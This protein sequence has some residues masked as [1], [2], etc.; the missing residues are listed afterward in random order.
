MPVRVLPKGLRSFDAQDAYFFLLL[1]PGPRDR[2]GLPQNIAFW[3]TRIEDTDAD[4]TFSVGLI[5]GPSGCGKSSLVKAGLLPRLSV[6]VI[7]VYLEAQPGETEARILR[8]LRKKCPALPEGLDLPQT[9]AAVRKGIGVPAGKKVLLVLDQFEQ[10]LHAHGDNPDAEL[11]RALRHCDGTHLQCVV[12]VRD[13]FWMA[14][15]RFMR[16]LEVRLRE[17]ENSTA[18]DLFNPR[19]ARKVLAEFGRAFGCLPDKADELSPEQEQFLDLAVA[20]LA[21]DGKIIP[22]R[23][24]L[25]TEML[26]NRAWTLETLRAVGGAHGSGVTFLEET[27]SAAT[28]PPEHRRHQRAAREVLR[29]LLPGHG[30]DI[31]GTMRSRTELSAASGCLR[32]GDFDELLHLLDNEL[33]LVT[34]ADPEDSPPDPARHKDRPSEPSPHGQFYQLTHDYLIPPLREWLTRKQRERWRGRAELTLAERTAQWSPAHDRRFLP[35]LL[36]FLMIR[37]GVPR[38]RRTRQQQALLMAAARHHTTLWGGLTLVVLALVIALQQYIAHLNHQS[39]RHHTETLVEAALRAPP[40]GLPYI[41]EN[42]KPVRPVALPLLRERFHDPDADPRTRLHAA[43]ALAALGETEEEFLLDAIASAPSSESGN[44]LSALEITHETALPKLKQRFEAENDALTK[45]RLALTLLHLG[46]PAAAGSF[47]AFDEDPIRRNAF[48]FDFASWRGNLARLRELLHDTRDAAL[49][50]GLC[51]ALG[52]VPQDV[53]NADQKADMQ[54]TLLELYREAPDGGTHN[55]ASWALRQWRADLPALE[56]NEVSKTQAHWFV[57]QLGM[58]LIELPPATFLMG[59]SELEPDI[60]HPVTLTRPFFLCD[61]EVWVDLYKQFV[62]DPA[63]DKDR[64]ASW[65]PVKKYCPSGDYPAFGVNWNDAV[66]FCNWLSLRDGRRS[67]YRPSPA[68]DDAKEKNKDLVEWT[69][70]FDA[71]GYRLPTEAEWEYACRA[72]TT[73]V[74]SFGREDWLPRYAIFKALKPEAVASRLPNNW[75]FFDM[76]GN[77]RELCWGKW[78]PVPPKEKQVDPAEPPSGS[79][80]LNRGG[81]WLDHAGALGSGFRNRVRHDLRDDVVGFRVGCGPRAGRKA[82]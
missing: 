20:E 32:Q 63:A 21:E 78:Y 47:L 56:P 3:K 17:G 37:W 19:H 1:L 58:T 51:T 40:D 57:N 6:H 39:Q 52:T 10:W 75:G 79:D 72:G 38:A 80:R 29:L 41:I 15:S 34:P 12:L 22:V 59:D 81:S 49:R 67:C 33:R 43:V 69:C 13:D 48:I 42:L 27:F 26:K 14:I 60:I 23:L 54:E 2:H 18:V 76:H 9:L 46:N 31:K 8:G 50:S 45:S 11:T 55:A 82:D 70:D 16:D 77:A 73:S 66:L 64:L 36:E 62:N 4:R 68:K 5:Y 61:R 44:V 25:F 71:D 53:L 65:A 28:A 7:P 35:S 74:W 30:A 24:S